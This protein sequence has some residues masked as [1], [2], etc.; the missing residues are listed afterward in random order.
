[1]PSLFPGCIRPRLT[2][3]Q[4]AE[5]RRRLV[6]AAHVL[7]FGL[8]GVLPSVT[9]A[10]S[11]LAFYNEAD[12]DKAYKLPGKEP[13][14]IATVTLEVSQP[15][16]VL[17]QFT[18]HATSEDTAGC[19]CSV[20]ASLRADDSAAKPVRR[21][22]LGAPGIVEQFKYEH[23]RQGVDGSY[24]FEAAPGKHTYSLVMQQQSGDSK[25]IEF[26]YPNLQAIAFP[27]Q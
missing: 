23:D 26:F 11:P 9:H 16:N 22:N 13:V 19:P 8:L 14:T 12:P 3:P 15:S 24:V 17:V 20:R 10:A 6:A 25:S 4:L 21:V 2:I 7:V 18:S 1:M 27:R 5:R